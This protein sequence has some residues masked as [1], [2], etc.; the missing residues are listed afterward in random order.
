MSDLL[1]ARPARA[2]V[3]AGAILLGACTAGGDGA[4]PQAT[5]TTELDSTGDGSGV[6]AIAFEN[7]DADDFNL[8]LPSR[9]DLI[10]PSPAPI[11]GVEGTE[12]ELVVSFEMQSH[13]CHGVHAVAAESDTEVTLAI[14]TGLLPAVDSA[15]CQY[16]VYPYTAAVVLSDPLGDRSISIAELREPERA[17]SSSEDPTADTSRTD[18]GV[19]PDEAPPTTEPG[20]S[21]TEANTTGDNSATVSP[22]ERGGPAITIEDASQLIGRP[23][24]DGV[25]WAIANDVEWRMLSYD[26]EPVAEQSPLDTSRISFVVDGDRI[27]RFEWS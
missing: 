4:S 23:I 24:E 3:A 12:D 14:E 27:V 16:G 18:E 5:P 19:E 1:S 15:A 13:H 20:G 10:D 7:P 2:V 22:M 8:L 17:A 9:D 21:S 6:P 26:G 25:E 11:L